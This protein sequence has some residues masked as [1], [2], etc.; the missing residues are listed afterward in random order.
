MKDTYY[1]PERYLSVSELF[2]FGLISKHYWHLLEMIFIE[3]WDFED[4][5]PQRVG[6]GRNPIEN[7]TEIPLWP[8]LQRTRVSSS[9]LL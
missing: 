2:T 6:S 9:W 1:R 8:Q 4:T 7:N 5:P 3:G